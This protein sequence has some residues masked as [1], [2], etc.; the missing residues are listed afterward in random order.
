MSQEREP[1]LIWLADFLG[2]LPTVENRPTTFYD[3]AGANDKE[4]LLTKVL[5]HFLDPLADHGMGRLFLDALLSFLPEMAGRVDVAPAIVAEKSTWNGRLDILVTPQA[6]PITVRG[7][8]NKY[9]WAIIVEHKIHAGLGDEQLERYDRAINA[10]KKVM[11]L[12]ALHAPSEIP[13]GVKVVTHRKLFDRIASDLHGAFQKAHPKQLLYLQDLLINIDNFYFME[14]NTDLFQKQL[15]Q[16]KEDA[17]KVA[18]FDDMRFKL[19]KYVGRSVNEVLASRG[20]ESLVNSEMAVSRWYRPSGTQFSAMPG[21]EKCIG[22]W[23]DIPKIMSAGVLDIHLALRDA[24]NTDH[25]AAISEAYEEEDHFIK[26]RGVEP[27]IDTGEPGGSE[28][29]V[30]GVHD[31]QL[32]LKGVLKD[33]I[34]SI[35]SSTLLGEDDSIVDWIWKKLEEEKQK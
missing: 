3:I 29:W 30:C 19:G 31:Y 7:A 8:G 22:L 2:Q 18:A 24:E 23:V 32:D 13:D 26:D 27:S 25:G 10:D 16:F 4:T 14:K 35:L 17:E 11:V 6:Q 9:E 28:Y 21:I 1:E 15:Q 20:F 33:E 5:V 34:E 12:L